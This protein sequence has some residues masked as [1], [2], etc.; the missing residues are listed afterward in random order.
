MR[1]RTTMLLIPAV[2]GLATSSFASTTPEKKTVKKT[3]TA[4]AGISVPPNIV[5]GKKIWALLV[6]ISTYQ[7]SNNI[8]SL[9]FPASDAAAIGDALKDP[10]LGAVPADH[11]LLLTNEQATAA[12]IKGAVD[13]F[14]RPNVKPG[15]TIIV[16]LA[17]H[18]IAKGVGAAAK[19][20]LLPYDVR[21]LT[22]AALDA[23]A[24]NLRDLS[25]ALGALPASQFIAFVDACREDPTPG[26]GIKGNVMTD[27]VNDSMQIEPDATANPHANSATFF[28]CSVGQR[29]YEDPTYQHGVFTY[30]ILNGIKTANVP[31]KPDGAIDMAR[32]AASVQSGVTGWAQQQSASGDFEIDQ[33]PQL[34][35]GANNSSPITLMD[36]TRPYPDHPIDPPTPMLTVSTYPEGADVTVDG[37][38]VG[39]GTIQEALDEPGEHTVQAVAPGYAPFQKTFNALP[40]Y[41]AVVSL[42]LP[43]AARGIDPQSAAAAVPDTFARAQAAEQRGETDVAEA[44]YSATIATNP[45]FTPA[46]ER[47]AGLQRRDQ[48]IGEYLGTLVDENGVNP[49][50]AHSLSILAL[51]YAQY[52]IQGPAQSTGDMGG[53]KGTTYPYPRSQK[54]AADLG[55]KAARAAIAADS[56]SAEA[57]RALGFAL[58]AQDTKLKNEQAATKAFAQ[59][60]F[61]DDNDAANH[62]GLG[63]C[64]RVYAQ[65]ITDKDAQTARL[66][67]AVTELNRAI[68][69]RPAYY[70]AHRELAYCYHIMGDR[71]NAE[72]EYQIAEGY[73]GQASDENEIA[74]DDCAMSALYNQDA[75]ATSDPDKKQ[76][77][78]NASDGCI[79]EAKDITPDLKAALG[80]LRQA[81]LSTSIE[82]YL[83]DSVKNLIDWQSTLQ[84]SI[85]NKLFGGHSFGG[86]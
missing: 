62:Y 39:A 45:D 82:D 83:P 36:V 85:S 40:G 57:Q 24:V 2:L 1:L 77:Y 66:Q 86:F 44:G 33:T 78:K 7:N 28:A 43:P 51:A 84:N 4:A 47:L 22:T 10:T 60:A 79:E 18:G 3:A 16:F 29:A 71:P 19:G 11:I 53:S 26:R 9:K 54:D 74:G 35:P 64:K 20:Y 12:N 32:L 31:A 8:A 80:V 52:F 49:P 70:E 23:S 17:G 41:P 65:Q 68:A 42:T 56:T 14:F 15:D 21:G 58:V 63:Y 75:A 5:M 67:E 76:Q 38:D 59:A 30:Y 61:M 48:H 72:K 50:T 27:V 37:K 69:L 81:G 25:N 46:Y 55:V 6:G 34:V 73:R 13:T